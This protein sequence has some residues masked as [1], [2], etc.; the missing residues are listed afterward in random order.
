MRLSLNS[1]GIISVVIVISTLLFACVTTTETG[2]QTTDFVVQRLEIPALV[3]TIASY[4]AI[5]HCSGLEKVEVLSGYFFWSMEGPFEYRPAKVDLQTGQIVFYLRTRN[6]GT[7]SI[8][9]FV[10]YKDKATGKT[11]K[12]KT[13]SAGDV[14][15]RKS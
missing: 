6:P 13:I 15:A 8:Q 9:G 11:G 10:S 3:S 2:L 14:T 1:A 12:S 5:M 7:Y 4:K